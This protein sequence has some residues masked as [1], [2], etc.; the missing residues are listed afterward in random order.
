MRGDPVAEDT[1]ADG[2]G[3]A[4]AKDVQVGVGLLEPEE[5]VLVPAWFAEDEL[6]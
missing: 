1:V 4:R 5:A 3:A 6:W 2:L